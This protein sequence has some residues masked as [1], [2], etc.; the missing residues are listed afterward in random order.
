LLQDPAS[1]PDNFNHVLAK[2][3]YSDSFIDVLQKW[4]IAN[5]VQDTTVDNG[6]YG[7]PDLVLPALLPQHTLDSYPVSESDTVPQYA[8]EYYTL[9][10]AVRRGTLAISLKGDPIVRIINNDPY[11][12]TN[13]WWSNRYDNMDSTLTH[14]FDLSHLTSK[15]AT[16]QFAAW[17]DLERDYDYAFVEVSTG[18]ANWTTLKGHYTTASNRNGANWG[19]GYTGTSGGASQPKWVQESVDLSPYVG[20]KIQLRFEQVTDEAVNLQGFAIDNIRIPELHFQDTLDSNNGWASSGFI[21]SNNVLP[22]HYNIQALLYQGSQ[23]TV[24]TL[25]VDL[26][27]GQGTLTIPDY[28]TTVTRVVLIVSA[29]AA[30]TTQIAHYQLNISLK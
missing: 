29:Y 25:T 8:A 22:Q 6:A 14:S 13:E 12:A 28:G 7:Y 15:H 10:P 20:K 24:S 27:S 18:G 2:H 5:F 23:F 21:R 3:G 19:Q 17:Y 30:E 4:Y 9:P 11:A 16:L 1:P 26:A